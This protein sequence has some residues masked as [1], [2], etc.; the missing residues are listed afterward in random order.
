M[1]RYIGSKSWCWYFASLMLLSTA[2]SAKLTPKHIESKT[3]AEANKTEAKGPKA[4]EETLRLI[5]SAGTLSNDAP[6]RAFYRSLIFSGVQSPIAIENAGTKVFENSSAVFFSADPIEAADVIA[7][8]ELMAKGEIEGLLGQS[9]RGFPLEGQISLPVKRYLGAATNQAGFEKRKGNNKIIWA[10][11][12]RGVTINWPKTAKELSMAP[13]V[14]MSDSAS[15]FKALMSARS[16]GSFANKLGLVDELLSKKSKRTGWVDLGSDHAESDI[17][18]DELIAVSKRNPMGF[19]LSRSDLAFLLKGNWK[20]TASMIYPF[21]G[22]GHISADGVDLWSASG[23]EKIWPLYQALGPIHSLKDSLL[24]MKEIATDGPENHLNI[25]KVF[26]EEAA[27]EA[28]RQVDVDLVLLLASDPFVQLPQKEVYELKYQR[29]DSFEQVAPVVPLSYLDVAVIQLFGPS[30]GIIDRLE[31][32]RYPVSDE[33]PKA[34]DVKERNIVSDENG[35]PKGEWLREG[36]RRVLGGVMLDATSADVAIFRPLPEISW[37]RG[38]VP[39]PVVDNLLNP[40]GGVAIITAKGSQVKNIAKMISKKA[41]SLDIYG[42]DPK[43]GKIGKRLLPD[44]ENVRVALSEGALLELYMMGAMGG[45][46][47]SYSVRAPFVEGIYGEVKQLFFAQ[48]PKNITTADTKNSIDEAL[49]RAPL[50]FNNIFAKFFATD[51]DAQIKEFLEY[52]YGRPHHVMTLDIAYLDLGISNNVA[53]DLY[54]KRQA[55]KFNPL[56]RGKIP[57]KA[58][59]YLLTKTTLTYDAPELITSLT[60]DIKYMHTDLGIKPERDK[61]KLG[62]RF[63]L[64]WE[65]SIFEQSRIIISP[66]FQ[67]EY[68]TQLVPHFLSTPKGLGPRTK[69]LESLLGLNFDFLDLGF[70]MDVGFLCATDFNR[71]QLNNALDFGPGIN[72]TSKWPIFGPLELSSSIKS[73]YLFPTPKNTARNKTALGI[74]GTAWLRFARFYDFSFSLMSDFLVTTLQEAPKDVSLSSIFG[75]TVSYG[76]L[77]RLFG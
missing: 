33:S 16:V 49:S 12:K 62:L 21:K 10:F 73:Y 59:L 11:S 46:N 61:T 5:A 37:I 43:T 47:E 45:F 26:S 39:Y 3:Q 72:F 9:Y 54:I 17:F 63:R 51:K 18:E 6:F 19:F 38:A 66:I 55:D 20:P 4:L 58:H 77:F 25:V 7:A 75:L 15:S 36:F 64:P 1:K 29:S 24:A 35:L 67:N 44:N 65:R 22:H 30:L 23:N 34:P 13:A 14:I 68:E 42:I 56:S 53:N 40:H 71:Y 76:R 69:R 52:P 28:A 31:I 48:G 70:N 57:A 32:T 41:L 74:E 2:L 8:N 27:R 50:D 60:A